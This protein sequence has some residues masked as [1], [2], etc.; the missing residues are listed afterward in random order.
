MCVFLCRNHKI[1]MT[2]KR[3]YDQLFCIPL[4]RYDTSVHHHPIRF[5]SYRCN[6]LFWNLQ[7]GYSYIM[8]R[9]PFPFLMLHQF[10]LELCTNVEN[11]F[12]RVFG[13]LS[14]KFNA[15]EAGWVPFQFCLSCPYTALQ[16]WWRIYSVKLKRSFEGSSN[17]LIPKAL[18]SLRS[19]A[20]TIPINQPA[21][22]FV[23]ITHKWLFHMGMRG[24]S[25]DQNCIIFDS[26]I[27][28]YLAQ[29]REQ[30]P[31]FRHFL[32]IG[33]ALNSMALE[34]NEF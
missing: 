15:T 11:F 23:F 21:T 24:I 13:L 17:R 33:F 6:M 30:T 9:T 14:V 31:N 32:H 34:R 26:T 8:Q 22:S 16:Q 10:D 7:R 12:Q 3:S 4:R 27:A 1:R 20:S 5:Q 19:A 28:T 25:K 18:C 29:L 2:K